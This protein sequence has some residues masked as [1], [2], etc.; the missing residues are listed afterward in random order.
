MIKLSYVALGPDPRTPTTN[1]P[2][3]TLIGMSV[4]V[5]SW[6]ASGLVGRNP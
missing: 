2:A 4:R 3:R 6:S 5:G 1:T